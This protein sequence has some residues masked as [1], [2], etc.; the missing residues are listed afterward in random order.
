MLRQASSYFLIRALNGVLALASLVLLTRL[1]DPAQYGMFSLCLTAI[2]VA[3]SVLFQWLNVSIARFYP[4]QDVA[5]GQL[6]G[7]AHRMF[8]EFSALAL[9]I[10]GAVALLQ[11]MPGLGA[12]L[13]L[14]VGLGAVAMG[15]HNLHLQ[16][17][18]ARGQP[19]RYGLISAT[20]AAVGLLLTLLALRAG[21]GVAGAVAALVLACTLAVALF[22]ARWTAGATPVPGLR[23]QLLRYGAP[24]AL[25]FAATMLLDVFDRFL[26]GWLRGPAEVAGYAAAY[27]LSQQTVGVVL[28]VFF[29]ANYPAITAAWERA[30]AAGARPA[31][32]TLARAML[33]AA[34]AVVALF[35][36]LAPAFAQLVFGPGVR[37]GAQT[38]MPWIATAIAIGCFKA[39]VLDVAFQLAGS[40]HLQLRITAAMAVLNVVLNLLAVP[41]LGVLG[42]ALSAT[43]AFAGGAL[44]S[45]WF[46]RQVAVYPALGLDLLKALACGALMA[47]ALRSG[48]GPPAPDGTAWLLV[49]TAGRCAAGLLVFGAAALA[50]NLCGLRRWAAR[51]A[52]RG[53]N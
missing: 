46:G 43:A 40:T 20:R 12:P 18:N 34:P 19:L 33:V 51:R 5:P 32:A 47:L 10:A 16:I 36:G 24:L 11:P 48:I 44:L 35:V 4:R 29:L 27:D 21:W 3:A 7:L 13:A 15:L 38:V 41:W 53:R 25:T 8:A 2:N 17:A 28:N 49:D 50:L 42:A 26:I 45:W 23:R 31:L 14:L 30:G 52:A 6:L 22:G 1:M 39:Y 9:L 37:D